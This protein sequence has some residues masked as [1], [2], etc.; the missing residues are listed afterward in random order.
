MSQRTSPATG[1]IYGLKRVCESWEMPRSTLYAK[2]GK[3]SLEGSGDKSDKR[4]PKVLV[5]DSDIV[6]KIKADIKAS[7]FKGECYRKIHARV[8]RQSVIVGKERVLRLMRENRLLSP[9]RQVQGEPNLHDGTIITDKPNEM[10]GTDAIKINTVDDGMVWGAF[11]VEHWNAECMGWHACKKGD[12]QAA[13]EPIKQGVKRIY[14]SVNS[15]AAIGLTLREDHGSQYTAEQYRNQ[16]KFWGIKI[17]YGFVQEPET[18]GVVE[19]F[20]RTVKEQVI[21]GRIFK[22]LE[23]VRECIG[24][25]VEQYN[26]FWLLEKMGYQSPLQAREAYDKQGAA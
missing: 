20:N 12:A 21:H 8:R 23:E 7:P 6:E 22:N 2:R 10:W 4:G 18:N 15:K 19:R 9:S 1:K 16:L 14:G 11:A 5:S 24:K 13:L 17:S 25:F 26:Q 3:G